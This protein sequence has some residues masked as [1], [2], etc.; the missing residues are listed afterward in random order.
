MENESEYE[1]VFVECP[2]FD[3]RLSKTEILSNLGI[4]K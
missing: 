3:R 2:M 4:Q 1:E